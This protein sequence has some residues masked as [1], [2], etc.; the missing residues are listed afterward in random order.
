VKEKISHII[1][2][3]AEAERKNAVEATESENVAAI[4]TEEKGR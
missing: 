3:S 4:Y 2:T 1:A